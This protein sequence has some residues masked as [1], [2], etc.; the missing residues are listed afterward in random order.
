MPGADVAPLRDI[1]RVSAVL[2]SALEPLAAPQGI[3]EHDWMVERAH[4]SLRHALDALPPSREVDLTEQVLAFPEEHRP[5]F[6]QLPR[7][8]VHQDLNEDNLFVPGPH[9]AR[10]VGVIDFNDAAHTIRVADVAIAAG[11]AM[12]RGGAPRANLI[13]VVRGYEGVR[14]L[15]GA[16]RSVVFPIAITR[17]C[18]NWAIWSARAQEQPT[19][20][21]QARSRTS[22]PFIEQI[23]RQDL[24]S[25]QE[26]VLEQLLSPAATPGGATPGPGRP[27]S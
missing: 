20:Y 17:L 16:E 6:A 21:G 4:H 2:T 26:W 23:V 18:I 5:T 11:Y 15:T 22:W 8:T 25:A 24:H 9:P 10:V 3:P 7:S 27:R 14:A 19:V 13:E 1:G 12:R